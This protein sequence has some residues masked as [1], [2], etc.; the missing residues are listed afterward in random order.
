MD[1]VTIDLDSAADAADVASVLD[2]LTKDGPFAVSCVDRDGDRHRCRFRLKRD[3]LVVGY[4][5]V[6]DLQM[7]IDRE[8]VIV[9]V[10]RHSLVASTSSEGIS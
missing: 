8:F 5:S 4:R 3:G 1:C 10:E 6:I 9:G 7:R 2:A